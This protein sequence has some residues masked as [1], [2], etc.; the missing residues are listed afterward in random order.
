VATG[1]ADPL[2]EGVARTP[3]P[4]AVDDTAVP[5]TKAESEPVEDPNTKTT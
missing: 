2:R 3:T 1:N 4:P 5:S